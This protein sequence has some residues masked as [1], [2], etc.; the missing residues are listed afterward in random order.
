MY[1]SDK[2]LRGRYA[3][4]PCR[5]DPAPGP[6]TDKPDG[7]TPA[8]A[9]AYIRDQQYGRIYGDAEA[10]SKGTLFPALYMPYEGG[11]R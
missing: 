6:D 11:R 7:K 4:I 8:Y 9:M 2:Y 5:A 1:N 3:G 10:L